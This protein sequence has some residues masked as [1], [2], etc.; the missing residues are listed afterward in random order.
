MS[1][2]HVGNI[3]FDHLVV[4]KNYIGP[5]GSGV[6]MKENNVENEISVFPNPSKDKIKINIG[7]QKLE[8][9]IIYNLAGQSLIESDQLEMS[10]SNLD[11]GMYF[12]SI[13]TDSKTYIK[14]I[15]KE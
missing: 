6:G 2:G 15:I 4:A 8:K 14:K 3:Y 10:T 11:C 12:I 1:A 7:S 5:M 13:Q 9:A